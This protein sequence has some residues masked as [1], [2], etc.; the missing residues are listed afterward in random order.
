MAAAGRRRQGGDAR[1]PSSGCCTTSSAEALTSHVLRALQLLQECH[2]P[3][4][5]SLREH[6]GS[7]VWQFF[8]EQGLPCNNNA[9]RRHA[10]CSGATLSSGTSSALCVGAFVGAFC[11]QAPLLVVFGITLQ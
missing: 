10:V 9:P 8:Q 5:E 2:S 6:V 1:R 11:P 3:R 7:P 4:L